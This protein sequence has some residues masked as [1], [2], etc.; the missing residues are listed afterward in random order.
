MN[1]PICERE[2]DRILVDTD[3]FTI[4]T[5]SSGKF[6]KP[7]GQNLTLEENKK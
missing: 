2:F 4:D 1:C 7:I 5:A 6:T 3:D